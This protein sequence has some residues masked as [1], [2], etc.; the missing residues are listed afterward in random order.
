FGRASRR[1]VAAELRVRLAAF[2]RL[3]QQR[4]LAAGRRRPPLAALDHRM[5]RG[6][7]QRRLDENREELEAVRRLD[8]PRRATRDE[9]AGPRLERALLAAN[10]RRPAAIEDVEH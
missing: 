7:R 2:L 1:D 10:G 4:E 9:D 3:R 8:L 6:R 5:R